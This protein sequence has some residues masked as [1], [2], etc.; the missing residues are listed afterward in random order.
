MRPSAT[1]SQ[2]A[3]QSKHASACA[4]LDV[5]PNPSFEARPNI[6]TLAPQGGAGYHPPCGARVS[7][8][9]SA[10]IQT[11]GSTLP[12]LTR[13]SSTTLRQTQC[14]ATKSAK[15]RAHR[16]TPFSVALRGRLALQPEAFIGVPSLGWLPLEHEVLR[17]KPRS[18]YGSV[19]PAGCR[20]SGTVRHRWQP[21]PQLTA[22][23]AA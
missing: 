11:L 3:R 12:L 10:S 15:F 6:K 19:T 7:L 2:S 1:A 8:L 5:Q 9:S 4:D 22:Q 20:S 23:S 14:C 17:S 16:H 18:Q 21:P 13:L